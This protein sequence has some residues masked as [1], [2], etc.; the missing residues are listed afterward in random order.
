MTLHLD[1]IV[2]ECEHAVR[3]IIISI[4]TLNDLHPHAA[5]FSPYA[6]SAEA[7]FY[8]AH[9]AAG[10]RHETGSRKLLHLSC[11]SYRKGLIIET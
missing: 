8:T 11:L 5:P 4:H 9:R 2:K 10:V 1:S 3:V 7:T 6:G